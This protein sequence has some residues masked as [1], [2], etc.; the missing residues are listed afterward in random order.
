MVKKKRQ[1]DAHD[2]GSSTDSGDDKSKGSP[3]SACQCQH[4]KSAV[5]SN[6]LRKKLKA[7]GLSLQCSLCSKNLVTAAA[8]P[9][10][11]VNEDG[12]EYDSTLWLCLRCGSQLCGR[13][14]NQHALQ[15][16]KVFHC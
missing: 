11:E 9:E 6:A 14:K 10:S 13:S 8:S 15:H 3:S 7:T 5:D 12:F 16:F 2:D 4:I 1:S